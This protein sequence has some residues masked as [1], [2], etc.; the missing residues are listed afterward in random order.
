MLY[1]S[2][3]LIQNRLNIGFSF[4]VKPGERFDNS[5]LL[6]F[7]L[8]RPKHKWINSHLIRDMSVLGGIFMKREPEISHS[9]VLF[10]MQYKVKGERMY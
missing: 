7:S 8:R 4:K 9:R 2:S 3:A 1:S 5:C 6:H 10:R